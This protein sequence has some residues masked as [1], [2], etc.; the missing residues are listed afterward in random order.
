MKN[1]VLNKILL[2]YIAFSFCA[3]ISIDPER[4]HTLAVVV[5]FVNFAVAAFASRKVK[6]NIDKP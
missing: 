4:S 2:I 1:R 5:V 6:F 3:M